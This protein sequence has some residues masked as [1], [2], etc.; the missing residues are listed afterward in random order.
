MTQQNE[1][2]ERTRL[3][4]LRQQRGDAFLAWSAADE[5]F[6][7]AAKA[8]RT[9]AAR[10]ELDRIDGEIAAYLDA[11]PALKAEEGEAA[12]RE[13]ERATSSVWNS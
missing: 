6:P 10:S 1:T 3:D 5:G 7:S 13:L 12:R 9:A 11:H 8:R 4:D 2:P